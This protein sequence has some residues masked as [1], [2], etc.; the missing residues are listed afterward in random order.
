MKKTKM[1]IIQNF[2][3]ILQLEMGADPEKIE[4]VKHESFTKD[5]DR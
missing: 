1:Q 4:N 3:K 5:L 2:G